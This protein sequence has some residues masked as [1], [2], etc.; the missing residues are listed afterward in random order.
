LRARDSEVG[1]ADV[2][3]GVEDEVLWFDVAMKY[4]VVVEVFD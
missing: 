4:L 2:A 3:D 1:E